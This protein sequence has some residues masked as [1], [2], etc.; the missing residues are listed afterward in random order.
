MQTQGLSNGEDSAV[1]MITR[2]L[3]FAF[4]IVLPCLSPIST[5]IKWSSFVLNTKFNEKLERL[6][7]GDYDQ[8]VFAY[9]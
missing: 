3:Y 6:N 2:E 5:A 8:S 9:S 4:S 7:I 1:V